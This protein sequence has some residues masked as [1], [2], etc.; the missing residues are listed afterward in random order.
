MRSHYRLDDRG[1]LLEC[2]HSDLGP[3]KPLHNLKIVDQGI[4]IPYSSWWRHIGLGVSVTTWTMM[5]GDRSWSRMLLSRIHVE[6]GRKAVDVV[7]CLHLLNHK[8]KVTTHLRCFLETLG[9][10]HITSYNFYSSRTL[11]VN[12]ESWQTFTE[13]KCEYS[14]GTELSAFCTGLGRLVAH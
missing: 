2:L 14:L 11:V 12:E 13:E 6:T 7:E 4:Y 5:C 8:T 10:Y 1:D 9:A 3:V